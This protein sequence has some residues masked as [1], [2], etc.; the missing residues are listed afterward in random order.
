MANALKELSSAL[1]EAISRASAFTVSIEHE[2]YAVSG[3]LID[4][5]RVLTA[6]HLVSDEGIQ[7]TLPDGTQSEARVLGR[8]PLHDLALIRLAKPAKAGS[9]KLA[10]VAVGDL[11]ISLKRDPID[12]IN[13]SLAMI[14]ASG[15]KLRLG[16]SAVVARYL[17]TDGDRL[18]GTTGGPLVDAEGGLAAI[19][20]F[21]RRMACELAIPADLAMERARLLADGGSIKKPYLGVRSQ[22]VALPPAARDALKGRQEQGLLLVWVDAGSSA[23][24]AG[25]EV[26]DILVGFAGTPVSEHE[27]LVTLLAGCGAGATVDVEAI[28]GGTLRSVSLTIG[29]A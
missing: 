14:S 10:A 1:R 23:Q 29:G 16:R 15:S 9:P 18:P 25:L 22:A 20:T 28:R 26:G 13:A 5:D 3:V 8:D 2:P 6:S 4:S 7:V 19:Q 27:E 24:G 12:G 21:T 17:Q 11:V